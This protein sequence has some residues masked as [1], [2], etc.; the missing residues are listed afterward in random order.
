MNAYTKAVVSV[1][2]AVL[3]TAQAFLND[4]VITTGEW[5]QIAIAF[6][7]AFGVYMIPNFTEGPMQYAKAIVAGLAPALTLLLA[8]VN[9]G[10][11]TNDSWIKIA[12]AFVMAVCVYFVP[13]TNINSGRLNHV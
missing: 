10:G 6:V 13:N 1:M 8:A 7:A 3:T 9:A 12:I 4:S 5:V 11:V 2:L